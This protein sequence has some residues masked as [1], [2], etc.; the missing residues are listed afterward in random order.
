VAVALLPRCLICC[1]PVL[2]LLSIVF[3]AK[4]ISILILCVTLIFGRPFVKRFALCYQTVVRHVLS[5]LS[6]CDVAV[7]WPNGWIDQDETWFAG[8]PRPWPH[9]VRWGPICPSPKGHSPICRS[10]F[11][12]VKWLDGL[13]CHA[14][15]YGGRPRPRRLC[16]R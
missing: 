14:T 3:A 8:R 1:G 12:V 6:V 16:V 15:W 10:I 13:R 7:L 5:V 11:V 4:L 9:S 2:L